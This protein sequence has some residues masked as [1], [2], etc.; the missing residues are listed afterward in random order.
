MI[1]VEHHDHVR[2]DR[3]EV[4]AHAA[5]QRGVLRTRA[6]SRKRHLAN[7][8]RARPA[9]APTISATGLRFY[10]GTF[11]WREHASHAFDVLV[12]AYQIR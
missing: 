6:K 12:A 11:F 4:F 5:E 3:F 7:W 1:G 2:V 9:N 8:A 10:R